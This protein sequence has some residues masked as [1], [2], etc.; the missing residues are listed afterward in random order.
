MRQQQPPPATILEFLE[1]MGARFGINCHGQVTELYPADLAGLVPYIR[2]V[3]PVIKAELTR[4]ALLSQRKRKAGAVPGDTSLQIGWFIV[5]V[6]TEESGSRLPHP[7]A[8]RV[9]LDTSFAH[10]HTAGTSE[11]REGVGACA[12]F[13]P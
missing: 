11:C 10:R 12:R 7:T 4:R 5:A 13:S 2:K 6:W 9:H 8:R 1:C 3:L